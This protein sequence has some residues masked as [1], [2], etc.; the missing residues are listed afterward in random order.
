MFIYIYTTMMHTY[1]DIQNK[2]NIIYYKIYDI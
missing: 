2:I 1:I